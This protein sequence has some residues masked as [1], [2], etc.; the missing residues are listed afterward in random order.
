MADDTPRSLKP[1][2][3]AA[4]ALGRTEDETGAIVPPIDVSATYLRDPDTTYSRGY[5]YGRVDNATV[6]H[7]ED[8]IADLEEAGRAML[9]GSGLAAATAVF[10]GLRRPAHIVVPEVMYWAL[11]N[12]LKQDAPS[13]GLEVSFVDAGSVDAVTSAIRPGGTSLVWLETP[14]NPT[15]TVSDIAAVAAL[16]HGA[17]AVLAVDSTAATPVFS[18]PLSL[19]ADIVMHSATKYMGGH[20]DLIAGALAFARTDDLHDRI[21]SVR[22]HQ[23]G[24]LGGREAA[25][26]LRS[27]RTLHLRVRRQA[28]TALRLALHLAEHPGVAEVLY[29][30]LPWH[31]NHAVARGQ[32]RGGFGGMLSIRVRGGRAAAIATAAHVDLWKR[33]TSLGSVESL[34][35][36]RASIE[37]EDTPCPDDLLRLSVGIEDADDLIADLE[38]ALAKAVTDTGARGVDAAE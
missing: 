25:L 2:T 14:A 4:Q 13:H 5:I 1:E 37:G 12:W 30:G 27:L 21:A 33:A 7:A 24:I 6:R 18:R 9:F 28:D 3:R 8:V 34:I 16:A 32:M 23:G 15:W 22:V 20:S 38:R 31:P 17:G 29:P 35:E 11:R 36:H 26:L 10:L 19:G